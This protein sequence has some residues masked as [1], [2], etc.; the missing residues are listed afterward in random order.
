ML[1]EDSFLQQDDLLIMNDRVGGQGSGKGV[2]R[3][4]SGTGG[5]GGGRG[6][7]GGGR[8][9]GGGHVATVSSGPSMSAGFANNSKIPKSDRKASRTMAQNRKVDAKHSGEADYFFSAARCNAGKRRPR[10][11][12]ES[13]QELFKYADQGSEGINFDKYDSIEVVRSGPDANVTPSLDDFSALFAQLPRWLATNVQKMGYQRPTPIQKHAV[14]LII[15]GRDVLCAAQTG[16]GKTCAFLLP[17]LSKLSEYRSLPSRAA[18]QLETP[19]RPRILVLAPTRELA[20]QISLECAKLTFSNDTRVVCCYG[21]VPATGQLEQLSYGV[22]VLVATP[23]RLTDFLERDIVFL[24]DCHALVL[25][26]WG[27]RIT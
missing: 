19:A 17:L 12:G 25:G 22:D 14:P 5:G 6:S 13:E 15:A 18:A 1:F 26:Q 10:Q 2:R 23:G 4:G 20:S 3:S 11:T 27:V 24:G 8:G 7:S 21:G 9:Q 16:S